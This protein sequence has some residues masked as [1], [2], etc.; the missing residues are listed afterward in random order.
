M[1]NYNITHCNKYDYKMCQNKSIK[2]V[3][4]V[5]K[6]KLVKF[7]NRMCYNHYNNTVKDNAM[8]CSMRV[9]YKKISF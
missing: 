5:S 3:L 7:I 2:I 8:Q 6:W 9:L 4:V 1:Y